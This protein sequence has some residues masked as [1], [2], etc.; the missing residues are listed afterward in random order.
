M[1]NPCLSKEWP[2]EPFQ[3]HASPPEVEERGQDNSSVIANHKR[4]EGPD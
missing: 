3:L 4:W 1:V 2:G